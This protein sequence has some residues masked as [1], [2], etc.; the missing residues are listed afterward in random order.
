MGKF[1]IKSNYSTGSWA[2]MVTAPDDRTK[3]VSALVDTLGGSLERIYWDVDGRG[4]WVIAELPDA[5][6]AAAVMTTV[7]TTA[8]FSGV[9]AHELLTQEQVGDVLALARTALHV[10]DAPGKSAIEQP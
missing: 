4:A 6:T 1:L 9:E 2:R 10:Y 8:A 5:V 7:A 3:A